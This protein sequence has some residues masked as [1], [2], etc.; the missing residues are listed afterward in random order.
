MKKIVPSESDVL[1]NQGIDFILNSPDDEFEVYL[2]EAG[3]D[4]A[5]LDARADAAFGAAFKT[6]G[7]QKRA[8]AKVPGSHLAELTRRYRGRLPMVRAELLALYHRLIADSQARGTQLSLQHRT[9]SGE[10]SVDELRE[11][12]AEI[13]AMQDSDENRKT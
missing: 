3:V 7:Q 11:V 4:V 1:L 13:Q 8:A 5:D 9:L 10:V 12:I 2:R 6:Y